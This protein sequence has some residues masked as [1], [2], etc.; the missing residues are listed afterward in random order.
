MKKVLLAVLVAGLMVTSANAATLGLRW[1]EAGEGI[2]EMMVGETK[3]VEVVWTFTGDFG[4]GANDL[5]TVFFSMNDA[6][7]TMPGMTAD[8]TNWNPGAAVGPLTGQVA[9]YA[10]FAAGAGDEISGYSTHV[11]GTFDLVLDAG[12]VDD[13]IDIT[14]KHD[15]VGVLDSTGAGYLYDHGKAGSYSGYYS[16]GLGAPSVDSGKGGVNPTGQA[17]DPL[18]LK[19]IVPEPAGLALLALGAFAALRRR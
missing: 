13:I 5:G 8:L 18:Q 15:T 19:V 16:Y 7:L 4:Y 12:N 11:I 3:T 6:P 10:A 9:Q 14:I 1:A 2:Q 17:A